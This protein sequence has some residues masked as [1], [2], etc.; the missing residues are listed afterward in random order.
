[1]PVGPDAEG[2]AVDPTTGVV[3]VGDARGAVVLDES[4]QVR[5]PVTLAAGPRHIALAADGGPFVIPAEGAGQV[6]LVSETGRVTALIRVGMWPHDVATVAGRI[7][8]GNERSDTISVL[9]RGRVVTTV[10]VVAQPGGLAAIGS[11]VAV[12]GVR[13]RRLELIDTTTLRPVAVVPA[14]TGPSHVAALGGRLYVVD[15]GGSHLLVYDIRPRLHQ[16]AVI[17]L[18]LSPL[19]IAVDT[20]RGR[21]WVTCTGTNSLIELDARPVTPRVVAMFPTVRQPD[22][23][24]VDPDADVVLVVGQREGVLQIVHPDPG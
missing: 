19:G 15:T 18:P 7:Y 13:A 12:V 9:A 16:V 23:V 1:M 2:I 21:L 17:A 3:A 6:G 20:H 11:D 14:E 10:P 22:S 8:V 4:G 24:A 5:A